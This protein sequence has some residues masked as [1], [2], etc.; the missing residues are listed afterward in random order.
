MLKIKSNILPS[1]RC[2]SG[3]SAFTKFVIQKNFF[4]PN[5]KQF[6]YFARFLPFNIFLYVYSSEDFYLFYVP[7][8]RKNK[9]KHSLSCLFTQ[10]AGFTQYQHHNNNPRKIQRLINMSILSRGLWVVQSKAEGRGKLVI[11]EEHRAGR[12]E[13]AG[14]KNLTKG[15]AGKIVLIGI[16][17][18]HLFFSCIC[19]TG[20]IPFLEQKSWALK[21]TLVDVSPLIFMALCAP[22]EQPQEETLQKTLLMKISLGFHGVWCSPK[23]R[24]M[25]NF[26][27]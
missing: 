2:L 14:S 25:I 1:P 23:W 16:T 6:F 4:F 22:Q 9:Q 21:V 11:R 24:C 3:K 13:I 26:C 18:P 15:E 7:K 19:T 12:G 20:N 17:T 5:L 27:C 8:G 10:T